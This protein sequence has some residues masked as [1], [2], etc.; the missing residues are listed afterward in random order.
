MRPRWVFTLRGLIFGFSIRQAVEDIL[1][2]V[3]IFLECLPTC[4]GKPDRCFG[5][6]VLEGLFGAYVAGLFQFGQVLGQVAPRE[7]GD[8]FQVNVVDVFDQVKI[9]HHHESRGGVDQRVDLRQLLE[10]LVVSLS[11]V[12]NRIPNPL[13]LRPGRDLFLER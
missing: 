13:A 4:L 6:L 12:H 9:G 2:V 10:S 7:T 1:Q 11:F 3:F 8:P 5:L